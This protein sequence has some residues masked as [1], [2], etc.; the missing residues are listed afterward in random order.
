MK[1][2]RN[3]ALI[4]VLSLVIPAQSISSSHAANPK[5]GDS[6]S[7]LNS[8]VT[9]AKVTY[10]CVK[11]DGK[12]VLSKINAASS[13][14]SATPTVAPVKA[15]YYIPPVP[16][17][18]NPIT[19]SNI[20]SRVK[21]IPKAIFDSL[22]ETKA[23]NA[24][25][26]GAKVEIDI[27][28]SPH[29]TDANYKNAETWFKEEAKAFANFAQFKKGYIFLYPY[30]DIAWTQAKMDSILN[31][32]A[33]RADRPYNG[34]SC[35]QANRTDAPMVANITT[36]W[37]APVNK[38]KPLD[39]KVPFVLAGYCGNSTVE[40][41]AEI[42]GTTHEFSHQYQVVQ[43]WDP[44]T[45][46]YSN[47][48]NA[49]PCW[50][51]EGQAAALGSYSFETDY[52]Q[53]LVDLKNIPRPYYLNSSMDGS[54]SEIAPVYWTPSDVA[55]YLK[56]SSTILPGCRSTNRFALSYSLG[57]YTVMALSAI[58]GWESTFSL[59]PMLN[60]GISLNDAFKRVYGIT[61]DEAL[62]TLSQVVSEMVMQQLN[63]P[64]S[65]IYQVK[66]S[67]NIVSLVGE[68]GCSVYDPNN[69]Q[70][71]R[72]RIQVLKDGTWLDV[73]TIE[74]SWAKNSNCNGV[75]GHPWLVTLKVALDHGA[76]Y[77]F[78]YLG[79]VNIGQSDEYGRGFSA[80]HTLP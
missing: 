36:G 12:L 30:E 68:E 9:Y 2:L 46:I 48:S 76:S 34:Q 58:G 20:T 49:A 72:A 18:P 27:I 71:T 57:T 38:A 37:D 78:L 55:T 64:S 50:S 29:V 63:P 3:I 44:K 21:D 74:Q 6:C 7:K 47:F 51:V 70:T 73:P 23:R 66:D 26:P 28:R 16:T 45:N 8:T 39:L 1:N 17:S 5:A 11:V 42:S 19:F 77:R 24:N 65:A 53:Y 62:P 54:S 41:W 35:E 31:D 25:L 61:W 32:V 69:S 14:G 15:N 79:Q 60:D 43:F 13:S 4:A 10:K 67:T 75:Q 52:Q 33:F 80:T 22:Q 59:L 40:Q 56:E